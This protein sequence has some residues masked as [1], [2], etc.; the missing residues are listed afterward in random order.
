MSQANVTFPAGSKVQY[1]TAVFTF[2]QYKTWSINN[3]TIQSHLLKN[4]GTIGILLHLCVVFQNGVSYQQKN[5]AFLTFCGPFVFPQLIFINFRNVEFKLWL[6][7]WTN[8][9]IT[10]ILP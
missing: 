4:L 10:I 7:S 3:Q 8:Y 2:P 5:A 6:S 1:N 9:I